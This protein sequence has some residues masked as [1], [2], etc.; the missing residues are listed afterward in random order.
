[1]S[2]KVGHARGLGPEAVVTGSQLISGASALRD[3]LDDEH[4]SARSSGEISDLAALRSDAGAGDIAHGA[5]RSSS[6]GP[7]TDEILGAAA[8]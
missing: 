4:L 2:A 1:V 3:N 6:S 5:S 7:D 8:A